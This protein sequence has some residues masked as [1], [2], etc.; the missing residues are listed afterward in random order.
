MMFNLK[1]IPAENLTALK[2]SSEDEFRQAARLAVAKKIPVD[3]PGYDTL[4]VRKEDMQLFA[5]H[6]LKL[7]ARK[8]SLI[9]RLYR[10]RNSPGCGGCTSKS[11]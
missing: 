4:I 9:P 7:F 11:N 3:A 6:G 1:T 2:F 5:Q 8:G 10:A